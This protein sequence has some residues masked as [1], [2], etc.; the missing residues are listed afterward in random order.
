LFFGIALWG[1]T[2]RI[3]KYG[4]LS[5][6]AYFVAIFLLLACYAYKESRYGIPLAP[7]ILDYFFRGLHDVHSRIVQLM[8]GGPRMMVV[9]QRLFFGLWIAGLLAFDAIL[10]FY[11]DGESMGPS[12]QL[13]L[14]DNESYL[15]GYHR[16]LYK[17]CKQLPSQ[18]PNAIVATDKFHK[19]LIRH[20]SGLEAHFVGYAPDAKF[21][22]FIQVDPAC[23]PKRFDDLTKS[24]LDFPPSLEGRLSNPRKSGFVTLWDVDA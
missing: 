4:W 19:Q 3:L 17:V 13:L 9:Q 5:T 22:V 23:L 12:S 7:F 10:I 1:F 14:S 8:R 21:T 18:Y 24:E 2:L 20:Y 11:G 16:D 6:D 15:R